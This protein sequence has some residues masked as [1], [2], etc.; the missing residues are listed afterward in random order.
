M[1][2][3]DYHNPA[4]LAA[5]ELAAGDSETFDLELFDEADEP[6]DVIAEAQVII[7][8]SRRTLRRLTIGRG[9]ALVAPNRLS[10]T[11]DTAGLDATNYEVQYALT[12]RFRPDLTQI[13]T[14][15]RN[16]FDY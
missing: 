4:P 6:V 13:L 9:L 14:V 10:V 11:I 8:A 1:S 2:E 3:L 5:I 15:A 16:G 7:Q 12:R